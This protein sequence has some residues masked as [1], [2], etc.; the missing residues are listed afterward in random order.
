M[1]VVEL[2]YVDTHLWIHFENLEGVFVHIILTSFQ[3]TLSF[4]AVGQEDLRTGVGPVYTDEREWN[5]RNLS[6]HRVPH[7]SD[8]FVWKKS[9]LVELTCD[10]VNLFMIEI[11]GS[12][13]CPIGNIAT[14]QPSFS[15]QIPLLTRQLTIS[16]SVL[17]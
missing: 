12:E 15:L 7:R 9:V 13:L 16:I 14:L 1:V 6:V 10:R 3:R 2:K 11:G 4:A 8:I 17:I 5:S